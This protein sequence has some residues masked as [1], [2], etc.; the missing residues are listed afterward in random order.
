MTKTIKRNRKVK[1]NIDVING[2]KTMNSEG[3]DTKDLAR[4][5]K[6]HPVTVNR[7]KRAGFSLDGYKKL[8]K[9]ASWKRKTPIITT[10]NSS[11]GVPLKT[12]EHE[13]TPFLDFFGHLDR[14]KAFKV[15]SLIGQVLTGLNVVRDAMDELDTI[16]K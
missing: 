12:I 6:V 8:C 7:I 14:A 2:M 5:F 3:Y 15:S 11:N 10:S 9:P 16:N 1:V 4:T 13:E